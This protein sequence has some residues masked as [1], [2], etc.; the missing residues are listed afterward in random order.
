[1]STGLSLSDKRESPPSK[2]K[3]LQYWIS[4][5]KTDK[6][7]LVGDKVYNIQDNQLISCCWCCGINVDSLHKFSNLQV[8]H[9]IPHSL[10]GIN[11]ESNYVLMCPT[12]HSEAPNI[13]SR[14]CFFYWFKHKESFYTAIS[15]HFLEL[16]VKNKNTF[17]TLFKIYDSSY[18][19]KTFIELVKTNMSI[20]I[21]THGS[22][23]TTSTRLAVVQLS[24]DQFFKKLE[25]N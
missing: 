11:K 6:T 15:K 13:N 10:K 4:F 25:S 14:D 24:L 20:N 16:V 1:M 3:I 21:S 12:C 9:V 18:L 7:A 8:C 5:L 19:E 23:I 2:E 22:V 17:K